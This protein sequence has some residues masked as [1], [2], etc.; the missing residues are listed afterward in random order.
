MDKQHYTIS[1]KWMT[2][3]KGMV[4]SPELYHP[5]T[6]NKN[7]IEIATPPQFPGGVPHIWSPE[8]LLTAAVSSCF[9]TTFLAISEYSKLEFVSFNCNSKG[10][11]EKIEGKFTVSEVHLFPEVLIVDEKHKEKAIRVLEKS[12]KACI[13]SNSIKSNVFME[14]KVFV[15]A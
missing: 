13:I 1:I 2:D 4:C 12:A 6:H 5:E 14:P 11:L 9:M 10:V 15:Q 8:H 7:C 3:R